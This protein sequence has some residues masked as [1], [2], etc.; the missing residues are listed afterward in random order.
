M[1][2]KRIIIT[3]N[4]ERDIIVNNLTSA[5]ISKK[6]KIKA[7]TAATIK[8]RLRKKNQMLLNEVPKIET[9]NFI[10]INGIN[11]ETLQR[12]IWITVDNGKLNIKW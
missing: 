5:E 8:T 1:R 7:G 3:E 2:R 6:Y 12:E 10:N 4:L 9:K 11:I